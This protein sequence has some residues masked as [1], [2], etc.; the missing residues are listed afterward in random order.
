MCPKG[1]NVYKIGVTID[2]DKRIA[3][4]EKQV[5]YELY[6]IK[7]VYVKNMFWTERKL[8]NMFSRFRLAGEW[9]VLPFEVVHNFENIVAKV[10]GNE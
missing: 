5:E 6:Y 2:I 4:K 10:V 9:F 7:S 8:H 3:R 1:R